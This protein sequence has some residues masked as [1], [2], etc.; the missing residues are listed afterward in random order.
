MYRVLPAPPMP[1]LASRPRAAS[2]GATR[3][4]VASVATAHPRAPSAIRLAVHA[5]R[6]KPSWRAAGAEARRAEDSSMATDER[7]LGGSTSMEPGGRGTCRCAVPL[8]LSREEGPEGLLD[9][10]AE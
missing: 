9:G 6:E 1:M 2:G 3:K 4:S 10:E 5:L 7:A 8:C